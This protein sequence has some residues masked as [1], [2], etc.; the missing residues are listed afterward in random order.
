LQKAESV[1]REHKMIALTGEE[2]TRFQDM[3]L[4]LPEPNERLQMALAEHGRI[5]RP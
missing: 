2:W 1:V 4:N 5:I 3:L